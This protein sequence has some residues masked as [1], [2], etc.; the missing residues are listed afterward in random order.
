M[1]AA[2]RPQQL[3]NGFHPRQGITWSYPL[4]LAKQPR[5]TKESQDTP[6]LY[7]PASRFQHMIDEK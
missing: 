5:L 6:G 2:S 7:T 3:I 4:Y 1:Q